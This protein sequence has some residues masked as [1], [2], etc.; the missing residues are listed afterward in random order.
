MDMY[1]SSRRLNRVLKYLE[2]VD[3]YKIVL[4][5]VTR[6]NN[7]LDVGGDQGGHE[8]G[9][10]PGFVHGCYHFGPEVDIWA[11]LQILR[12]P[13]LQ[14]DY[15]LGPYFDVPRADT[16]CQSLWNSNAHGVGRIP[17]GVQKSVVKYTAWGYNFSPQLYLTFEPPTRVWSLQVCYDTGKIYI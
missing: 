11:G 5:T 12:K 13:C 14:R 3:G 4:R 17:I 7:Y 8:G 10:H 1:T 6:P 9:E 2:K 16:A 15:R